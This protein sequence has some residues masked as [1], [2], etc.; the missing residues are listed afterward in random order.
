MFNSIDIRDKLFHF[1]LSAITYLTIINCF[2]LLNVDH[3]FLFNMIDIL[4]NTT[5][6]SSVNHVHEIEF[7]IKFESRLIIK[8]AKKQPRRN[9]KLILFLISNDNIHNSKLQLILTPKHKAT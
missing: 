7:E 6:F 8:R 4:G 2:C 3:K 1:A 9:K 5:C